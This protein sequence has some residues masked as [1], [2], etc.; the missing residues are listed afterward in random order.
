MNAIQRR[1][2]SIAVQ[3]FNNGDFGPLQRILDDANAKDLQRR[4]TGH[5]A[6]SACLITLA[7]T[8]AD[9]RRHGVTFTGPPL[10]TEDDLI[11]AV[12]SGRSLGPLGTQLVSAV[13]ALRRARPGLHVSLSR[14][15]APKAGAPMP[16]QV[17]S[18][19]NRKTVSDISRNMAGEITSTMQVESDF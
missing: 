15:D 12:E 11:Y 6:L 3:F 9:A 7:R 17:V 16:V 8:L 2:A 4:R 5:A 10:T 19:P 1:G 18:M 13:K 14:E